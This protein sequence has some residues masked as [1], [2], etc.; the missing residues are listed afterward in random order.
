M[1]VSFNFLC[2]LQLSLFFLISF[3]ILIRFVSSLSLQ[4]AKRFLI[5][6]PSTKDIL[7]LFP[8]LHPLDRRSSLDFEK[9]EESIYEELKKRGALDVTLE[10]GDVYGTK[11]RERV[12]FLLFSFFADFSFKDSIYPPFGFIT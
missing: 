11:E 8:R 5:F 6:P 4:G 3:L 2:F 7:H 10:E 9:M 1:L 12:L